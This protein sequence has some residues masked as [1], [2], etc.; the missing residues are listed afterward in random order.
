MSVRTVCESVLLL[1]LVG[2]VLLSIVGLL[3]SRDALAAV[4]CVSLAGVAVPVLLL[5]AVAVAQLD[6]E[7]TVKAFVICAISLISSPIAGHALGRAIF[8]R[9]ER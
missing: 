3:R 4:H 1:A 6:A 9:S 7:A 2:V 8:L 5:A